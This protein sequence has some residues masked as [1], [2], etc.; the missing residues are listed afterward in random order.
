MSIGIN[1]NLEPTL[2]ITELFKTIKSAGFDSVMI[3]FKRG[4]VEEQ[5]L[6][7]KKVRLKIPYAHLSCRES[8]CFWVKSP[9]TTKYISKLKKEIDICSNY[10][11]PLAVIHLATG[12][13]NSKPL[14]PNKIGLENIKTIVEYG[15]SKNVKIALENVDKYTL[16]H[17]NY[18]FKNVRNVNSNSSS[19]IFDQIFKISNNGFF[20]FSGVYVLPR[21]HRWDMKG[22]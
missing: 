1:T 16:R 3:A 4:D 15:I 22:N 13:P 9:I 10:K 20:F 2:N 8:N 14:K 21:L 11:I 17:L 12:N 6:E 5:I 19:G 7:A 18:I